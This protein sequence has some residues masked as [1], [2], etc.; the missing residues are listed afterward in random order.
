[1][2]L[3]EGSL[4]K[5]PGAKGVSISGSPAGL[6][7]PASMTPIRREV[8][9]NRLANTRPAVPP[10]AIMTSNLE[11]AKAAGSDICARATLEA[12]AAT[13]RVPFT[14]EVVMVGDV[15]PIVSY[16]AFYTNSPHSEE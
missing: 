14:N 7:W 2:A 12:S 15:Y 1:M 9:D 13:R 3:A 4:I 11:A 8:E 10:P 5:E 16:R 6:K